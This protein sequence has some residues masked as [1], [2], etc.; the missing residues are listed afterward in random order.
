MNYF[1]YVLKSLTAS[2]SYTGITNNL[3]RRLDEHNAGKHFDTK[4]H[5]PWVM[6]YNE[7]YDSL[8][9]ARK[10]EKY[11]KSASGRKFLREIF[12]KL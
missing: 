6:I 11:L 1:V 12:K 7:E 8:R 2:K 3:D 4:R 10:R 9:E 5:I